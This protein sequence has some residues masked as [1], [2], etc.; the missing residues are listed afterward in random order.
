MQVNAQLQK[1]LLIE[2]WYFQYDER[3]IDISPERIEA[4][5]V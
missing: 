1:R 3:G 5:G 4:I 2:D